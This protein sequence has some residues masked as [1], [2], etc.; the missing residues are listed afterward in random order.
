MANP[1]QLPLFVTEPQGTKDLNLHTPF[2]RALPFFAEHLK[3]EGKSEHTIKAFM[4]DL[5]LLAGHTG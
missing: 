3:K 2:N 5:N 4:A 1:R